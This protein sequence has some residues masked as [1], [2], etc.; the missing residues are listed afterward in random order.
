[1]SVRPLVGHTFE[2]P[3]PLNISVQQSSLMPPPHCPLEVKDKVNWRPDMCY[4]FRSARTSWIIRSARTSWIIRSAR[5]SWNTFARPPVCGRKKSGS[6][7]QLYKSTKDHCQPI[8]YCLVR[9][10]WYLLVSG[11]CLVVSG[12]VWCMSGGVN[13]QG[14]FFNWPPPKNHKF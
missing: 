6:T 4:I 7:L 12:G 2:F 9:V 5:T 11:A 1:M 8:R 13:V 10:W 14:D 3:L